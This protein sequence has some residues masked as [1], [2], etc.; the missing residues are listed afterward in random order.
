M[1]D[2]LAHKNLPCDLKT[3]TEL[4]EQSA[5]API[6]RA[7]CKLCCS[8][9]RKEIEEQFEITQNFSQCHRILKSKGEDVPYKTVRTHLQVHYAAAEQQEKV[10]E[11][12]S[13]LVRWR[14][15]H[16]DKESRVGTILAILE[17]RM[18]DIA[19]RIDGKGGDETLK[20]TETLV[21]LAGQ[22][23][24]YQNELDSAKKDKDGVMVFVDQMQNVIKQ[25]IENSK[26]HE[27]KK[28][29]IELVGSL[30]EKIGGLIS[31]GTPI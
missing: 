2:R 23:I 17:R 12:A 15:D 20:A 26:N 6:I 13:E 5:S 29:L 28:G 30:E 18:I 4:A 22:I 7:D 16:I 8:K 31:N 3:I 27:V 25:H 24:T 19:A 9:Y 11:F 10:K 21:K 14:T 1:P